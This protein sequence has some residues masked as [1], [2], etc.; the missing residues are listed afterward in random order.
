MSSAHPVLQ[1]SIPST[2]GNAHAKSGPRDHLMKNAASWVFGA[3]IIV[4][5]AWFTWDRFFRAPLPAQ[6]EGH[7]QRSSGSSDSD[8]ARDAA[9]IEV[10]LKAAVADT[11]TAESFNDTPVSLT[12]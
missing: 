11:D 4:G 8:L 6:Q 2:S 3:L 5:V 12:E 9:A 7:A 10:Q 1:V